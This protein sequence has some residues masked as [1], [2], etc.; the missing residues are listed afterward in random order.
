MYVALYASK[1]LHSDFEDFCL[2]MSCLSIFFSFL[3][4]DRT[5]TCVGRK[6]NHS[7]AVSQVW[8]TLTVQFE[9]GSGNDGY[10]R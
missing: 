7:Q 5:Y 8:N 1:T 10:G 9:L 4:C 3:K 2:V 6:T